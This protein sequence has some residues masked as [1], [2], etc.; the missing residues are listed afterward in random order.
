[1][2]GRA[3]E[4]IV[5]SLVF[6]GIVIGLLIAVILVGLYFFISWILSHIAIV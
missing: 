4:G 6:M 2:D 1:M 3:F 5:T